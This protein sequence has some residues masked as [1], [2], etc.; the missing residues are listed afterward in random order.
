MKCDN[1]SNV[2]KC[3]IHDTT[4]LDD[5]KTSFGFLFG[6]SAC[7]KWPDGIQ[8]LK[9]DNKG[10][11]TALD[12]NKN[13]YGTKKVTK[14]VEWNTVDSI[15]DEKPSLYKKVKNAVLFKPPE[16]FCTAKKNFV[17][18]LKIY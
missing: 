8:C 7:T 18:P 4:C 2:Q 16:S 15:E 13:L 1:K 14:C 3:K 10:S 17:H 9:T 12:K 5:D 6:K 11:E